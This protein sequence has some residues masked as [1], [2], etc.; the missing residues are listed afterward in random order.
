MTDAAD[1]TTHRDRALAAI[2]RMKIADDEAKAARDVRDRE[3]RAMLSQGKSL[4]VVAKDVNLSK[5]LVRVIQQQGRFTSV[6]QAQQYLNDHQ[7]Q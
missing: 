3:V 4:G 1:Y 2:A 6:E 7:D 5:S